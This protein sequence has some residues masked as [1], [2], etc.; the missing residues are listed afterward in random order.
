M[1]DRTL[2]EGNAFNWRKRFCPNIWEEVYAVSTGASIQNYNIW[3]PLRGCTTN[4]TQQVS[5]SFRWHSKSN[6]HIFHVRGTSTRKLD[7]GVGH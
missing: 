2:L 5:D 7:V 6:A 3:I 1:I 4:P